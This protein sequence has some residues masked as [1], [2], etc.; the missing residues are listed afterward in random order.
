MLLQHVT[1]TTLYECEQIVTNQRRKL[2][3]MVYKQSLRKWS[4]YSFFHTKCYPISVLSKSLSHYATESKNPQLIAYVHVTL[5]DSFALRRS[6]LPLLRWT[7]VDGWALRRVNGEKKTTDVTLLHSLGLP[8]CREPWCVQSKQ[9]PEECQ[10]CLW[11]VVIFSSKRREMT[12]S[13]ILFK[14]RC[15]KTAGHDKYNTLRCSVGFKI[16]GISEIS[17]CNQG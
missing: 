16:F 15:H 10:E 11:R 14:A 1:I 5:G 3:C 7:D 8:R 13:V 4:A 12:S 17:C 9:C 2:R 6:Y